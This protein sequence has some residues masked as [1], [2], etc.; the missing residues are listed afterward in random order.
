MWQMQ[1]MHA[2]HK[3]SKLEAP[4]T[5]GTH[6][7]IHMTISY[8]SGMMSAPQNTTLKMTYLSSRSVRREASR[9]DTACGAVQVI[10]GVTPAAISGGLCVKNAA[11]P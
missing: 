11:P 8:M 10:R 4:H 2:I 9:G 5:C 1:C 6:H 7:A 3:E